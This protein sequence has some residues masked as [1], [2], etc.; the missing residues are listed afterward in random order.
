VHLRTEGH[1]LFLVA[2]T[3]HLL[4]RGVPSADA[5]EGVV[6][7]DVRHMIEARLDR[8]AADERL[9][10]EA[11]SVAGVDFSA[12][13][14]A[15][16]L[17]A[18][19]ADADDR[20]AG[21]ARRRM[22]VRAGAEDTWPDG[23]AAGRYSFVH[24]LY[25][26]VIYAQ[27]P[28]ARRIELHRRVAAREEA[29]HGP[30]AGRIAA[31]LAM[32]FEQAHD[33]AAALRYRLHAATNAVDIGGFPEAAAHAAAGLQHLAR[34]DRTR[35]RAQQELDLQ[36]VLA[37]ALA[38]TQGYGAPG[39]E[40]A[41][42]RVLE[43]GRE[44]GTTPDSALRGVFMFHLVRAEFAAAA[45]VARQGI[46]QAR[47]AA[48][49]RPELWAH[50]SLGVTLVHRGRFA[51]ARAALEEALRTHGARERGAPLPAHRHNPETAGLSYLAWCAWMLGHPDQALAWDREGRRLA[52]HPLA[53]AQAE[54]GSSALH[55][56]LGDARGALE[57]AQAS[58]S[59]AIEHGLAHWRVMSA[60]MRGWSRAA[61]GEAAEG[62]AEMEGAVATWRATG[63]EFVL[64]LI[65]ALLGDALAR[66]DRVDE[67]QAALAE[68]L[69]AAGRTGERF[70]EPEVHRLRGELLLRGGAPGAA[71]EAFHRALETA[72]EQR[73][74]SLELR[75][76]MS[77]CRLPPRGGAQEGAARARLAGAHAAF[78]EG[79]ETADLRA[80]RALL[81][82]AGRDRPPSRAGS[83]TRAG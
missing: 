65:L 74:R 21:L 28:V 54:N 17:E 32:H 23:T 38:M 77:L 46:G 63:A 47:E 68:A 11:A 5:L 13:S 49:S 82:A 40:L 2:M 24:S 57:H 27:V 81:R 73:A 7:A 62:I 50:T 72:R 15:A 71:A 6:P 29:G 59:L 79:F 10:V 22:L 56:F 18:S 35:E 44:L 36:L 45:E 26:D 31:R 69:R 58:L 43:L 41:Y 20:C 33:L 30:E 55:C 37:T 64:P 51:E 25:R 14:V 42:A 60:V 70:W 1:P 3:E 12:A 61:L 39:A 66:A 19:V 52:A 83:G 8:L 9:V 67:A 48:G 80:A 4:A 76:A 75:A 78:T 34:L 53:R 16:G